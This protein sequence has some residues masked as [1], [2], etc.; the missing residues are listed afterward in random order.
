MKNAD[1]NAAEL[2]ELLTRL[3]DDLPTEADARRLNE[4]LRGDPLACELYLN[5]AAMEAQFKQFFSE[6]DFR[7]SQALT[8]EISAIRDDV[9]PSWMQ[10]RAPYHKSQ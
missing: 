1:S 4:L 6:D 10:V 3:S 2:G 5:H 7:A 8:E 9:A